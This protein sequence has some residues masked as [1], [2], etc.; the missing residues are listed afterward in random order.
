LSEWS[1]DNQTEEEESSIRLPE[2]N[3]STTVSSVSS[4]TSEQR[5]RL[6]KQRRGERRKR[7]WQKNTR[8]EKEKE[9]REH[10][11]DYRIEM[12]KEKEKGK[13]KEIEKEKDAEDQEEEGRDDE[14]E[15]MDEEEEDE[16]SNLGCIIE[17]DVCMN[18]SLPD[19]EFAFDKEISLNA[20]LE[21]YQRRVWRKII[22]NRLFEVIRIRTPVA[23]RKDWLSNKAGID[24]FWTEETHYAYHTNLI[25]QRALYWKGVAK[26]E[27]KFVGPIAHMLMII[28]AAETCCERGF[29]TLRR[30]LTNHRRRLTLESL[31]QILRIREYH[32][33][34]EMIRKDFKIPLH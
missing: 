30:I 15:S 32:R 12:N 21:L 8:K 22:E 19:P 17:D 3:G 33:Q 25:H 28:P 13:E 24:Q 6:K 11:R 27:D 9:E 26:S 18:P 5:K 16:N 29:S 34:E 31:N 14:E 23:T 2:V 1:D 7:D 4:S 20:M 10:D